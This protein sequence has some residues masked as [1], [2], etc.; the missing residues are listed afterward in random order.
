MK[1]FTLSLLLFFCMMSYGSYMLCT[2]RAQMVP[3]SDAAQLN[4]ALEGMKARLLDLQAQ[5][6][7]ATAASAQTP[8]TVLSAQD[9]ASL[10]SAFQALTVALAAINRTIAT[11]PS[12]FTGQNRVALNE[13]LSSMSASLLAMNQ[14]LGETVTAPVAVN[15]LPANP[16]VAVTPLNPTPSTVGVSAVVPTDAANENAVAD[17][18]V[19]QTA[20]VS[21]QVS[22]SRGWMVTFGAILI[23]IAAF[24]L[25]RRKDKKLAPAAS[26]NRSEKPSP[27]AVRGVITSSVKNDVKENR[28]VPVAAQNV[29]ASPIRHDQRENH[30]QTVMAQNTGVAPMRHDFKEN[31][32]PVSPVVPIPNVNNPS[33]TN[34]KPA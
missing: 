9:I 12:E 24:L 27:V 19:A 31:R 32:P 29:G 28:P 22:L 6:N 15:E 18:N 13:T 8:A 11:N 5:A 4:Q 33:R 3:P 7:A 16:S 25:F 2:A 10:Q 21:S 30:P 14:A 34:Q 17:N 23:V 26:A 1:K 20:Q